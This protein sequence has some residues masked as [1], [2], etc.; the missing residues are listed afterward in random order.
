MKVKE[1]QAKFMCLLKQQS[2]LVQ[3]MLTG[4]TSQ[5]VHTFQYLVVI[6][7]VQGLTLES[8]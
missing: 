8:Q 6:F 3:V 7:K 2:H 5:Q 1:Q 4:G